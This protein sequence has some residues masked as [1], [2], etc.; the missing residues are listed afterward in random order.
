MKLNI[1]KVSKDSM[2]RIFILILFSV[3]CYCSKAYEFH[4]NWNN[5]RS[6][7]MYMN[8]SKNIREYIIN[9]WED[10]PAYVL[11]ELE[12]YK[13]PI[14]YKDK[15]FYLYSEPIGISHPESRRKSIN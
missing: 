10:E 6:L 13:F 5:T 1:S 14:S 15:D 12:I 4:I 7:L 11:S 8:D 3:S 2:R 9:K